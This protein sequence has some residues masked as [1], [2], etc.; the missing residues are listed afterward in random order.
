MAKVFVISVARYRAHA[1][2]Q[3][4][5]G[6]KVGGTM[7]IFEVTSALGT[8]YIDAYG[9]TP[10]DRR[11][12]AIEAYHLSIDGLIPGP[13]VGKITTTYRES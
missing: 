5:R 6:L 11:K 4:R 7:T 3:K 12:H 1:N 2:E 8:R 9:A 13:M 10:A